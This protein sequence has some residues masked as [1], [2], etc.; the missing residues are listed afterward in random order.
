MKSNI[1]RLVALIFSCVFLFGAFSTV[2]ASSTR[3][4]DYF[5]YTEVWATPQ[6]NGKFIVEFD[7]NATTEWINWGLTDL[8]LGTAV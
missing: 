6:G 2:S 1:T 3:A 8:Y 5:S 7:I 4:S